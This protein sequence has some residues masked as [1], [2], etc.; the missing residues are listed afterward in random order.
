MCGRVF[1]VPM[2]VGV[3]CPPPP[4]GGFGGRGKRK[5]IR[6]VPIL[7]ME[8][9]FLAS[10][11]EP[12]AKTGGLADVA[13]SLPAALAARGI[14]VNVFMPLYGF[15]KRKKYTIRRKLK[16]SRIGRALTGGAG[17]QFSIYGVRKNNVNFFFIENDRYFGRSGIYGSPRGEYRDNAARFIFFQKAVIAAMASL[18]IK[19]DI[20][21]L[22]DWHTALVPRFASSSVFSNVPTVLTIHNLAY[23]GIYGAEYSRLAGL[24]KEELFK[25]NVNFLAYGIKTADA[26]TTVSPTYAREIKTKKFGCG[27]E[28]ILKKRG[29]SLYGILNGLDYSSWSPKNDA[30]LPASYTAADLKGKK[31]CKTRLLASLGIKNTGALLA[32]FVGR[33]TPQKGID[34]IIPAVERSIRKDIQFVFLGDGDV[35]FEASLKKLEKKFPGR[36]SVNGGFNDI[37]AHRIYASSDIFLMPSEFEPCG[38]AQMIALSY[39]SIPVVNP[40]G[41]LKDTVEEYSPKSGAGWGFLMKKHSASSLAAAMRR[42]LECYALTGKWEKLVKKAMRISF[43]W[44]G[45]AKKYIALYK[46]LLIAKRGK[47][48]RLY[49]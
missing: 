17:P 34:I 2:S 49:A 23:Q 10:E 44:D 11:V 4:V 5:R 7:F 12:F 40:T 9:A 24:K 43:S 39:G 29:N 37:L 19:A 22:N 45:P 21:H 42:A 6:T 47:R 27:L 30:A 16:V 33:F 3:T 25:K 38:L 35:S 8:I 31:I 20:L 1:P 15:V 48:G 46:R 36:I 26:V 28:N 14:E 13:R 18:N 41:G 32:G